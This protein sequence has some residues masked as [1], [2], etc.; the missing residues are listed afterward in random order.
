[1]TVVAIDFLV[2]EGDFFRHFQIPSKKGL[3]AKTKGF[4][5]Q[6]SHSQ[7]IL[8]QSLERT[9]EIGAIGMIGFFG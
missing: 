1:L 2:K 3:M 4:F 7:H 6:G 8:L 9:S 5:D